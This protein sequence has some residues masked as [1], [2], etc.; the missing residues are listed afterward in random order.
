MFMAGAVCTSN[1]LQAGSFVELE[2]CRPPAA[3]TACAAAAAAVRCRMLMTRMK[4]RTMMTLSTYSWETRWG[5]DTGGGGSHI[6]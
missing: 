3:L 1:G 5:D 4:M 2:H 6:G